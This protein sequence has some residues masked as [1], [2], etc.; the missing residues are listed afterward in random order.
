MDKDLKEILER[1]SSLGIII[2]VG[3]IWDVFITLS[4]F[5]AEYIIKNA[6]IYLVYTKYKRSLKNKA[7]R[8]LL[9]L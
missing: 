2:I 1:K 5:V 9:L 7:K 8:C 3:L 4:I 6:A